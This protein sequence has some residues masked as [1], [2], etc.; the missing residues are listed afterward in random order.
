MSTPIQS[1]NAERV[2]QRLTARSLGRPLHLFEELASTNVTAFM[3]ANAG[4][5]HG[6]AILAE[7]QTAGKGRSGRHWVSPPHLNIYCSLILKNQRIS[8]HASWLPLVTGLALSEATRR[9]CGLEILL[10]WP[11]DL[12]HAEKKIG[13]ILCESSS[14]GSQ[15]ST[16]VVGFGMNVNCQETDFPEELRSLATSCYQ[17]TRQ[18]RDRNVLVADMFNHL[19]N[20][21]DRMEAG[22]FEHIRKSYAASCATL[23]QDVQVSFPERQPIYGTA[24]DIG[25]DGALLVSTVQ[26]GRSHT[27]EIRSGDVH[28]LR[29]LARDVAGP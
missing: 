23:G 27:M 24:T 13:G 12:L 3:L 10:K 20:W 25:K 2:Q 11:N 14:Q 7:S 21:Y 8:R 19:E 6:T 17:A 28:H 22:Q 18:Y 4:A 5:A 26:K 16:C 9:S 29:P 1:L 15:F